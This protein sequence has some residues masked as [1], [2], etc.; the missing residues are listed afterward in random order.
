MTKYVN[1]DI[2][3]KPKNILA[4]KERRNPGMGFSYKQQEAIE[5]FRKKHKTDKSQSECSGP[6]EKKLTPEQVLRLNKKGAAIEAA[7]VG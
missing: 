6:K 2:L 4:K 1:C 3:K 5:R 7:L